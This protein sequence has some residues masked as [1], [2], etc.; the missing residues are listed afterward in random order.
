MFVIK[1]TH[2]YTA[3]T[4]I[5]KISSSQVVWKVI[6]KK[7]DEKGLYKTFYRNELSFISK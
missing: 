5:K 4:Y 2:L 3:R 6:G 7:S 1:D